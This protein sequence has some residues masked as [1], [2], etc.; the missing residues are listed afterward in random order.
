MQRYVRRAYR[1]LK[2][3]RSKQNEKREHR[4]TGVYLKVND[5]GG[6]ERDIVMRSLYEF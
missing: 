4:P 3:Q 5:R 1:N 6:A 2:T